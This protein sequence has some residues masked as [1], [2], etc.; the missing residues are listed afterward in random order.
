MQHVSYVWAATGTAVAR[1]RPTEPL[2]T[3]SPNPEHGGGGHHLCRHERPC[4]GNSSFRAHD[5]HSCPTDGG[6]VNDGN[7]MPSMHLPGYT[8][9]YATP[10]PGSSTEAGNDETKV[11][12]ALTPTPSTRTG[13]LRGLQML[14]HAATAPQPTLAPSLPTHTHSLSMTAPRVRHDPTLMI[15]PKRGH[16]CVR[17]RDH[18]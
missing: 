7:L 14:P 8:R 4:T 5:P 15:H 12:P 13:K 10:G 1:W 9:P 3:R 18:T 11:R 16:V 6:T 2:P 17:K